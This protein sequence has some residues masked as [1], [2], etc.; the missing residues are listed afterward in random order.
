MAARTPLSS[1]PLDLL[2]FTFFLI[3][4]PASLLLD[5]QPL[6]PPSLVPSF[7]SQ[8]PEL[9]IQFSADPL[10]GGALG[11]F[12]TSNDFTWFKTFLLVEAFFQIP[13]FIL[14]MKG[15]WKNS[16]CIYVLI[17]IYGASTATTT[18]P[19]L[20]VLFNTPITSAETIAT[21]VQSITM[22][23]RYMLLSSYLPF[24]LV[25]ML[26]TIDMATR[27]AKL[28]QAGVAVTAER[29]SQ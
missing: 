23:Q 18:L 28:V 10:V 17:L 13:V 16:R 3:H 22:S 6:Y 11:Y 5:C 29:K 4:L 2:Y 19:C 14:G 27:I 26:M 24:F 7:I 25:P 9:Y 15:L 12:G 8:L 1:R 20:A 21:G